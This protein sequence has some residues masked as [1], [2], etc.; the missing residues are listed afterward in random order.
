MFVVVKHKE[1]MGLVYNVL[2]VPV[3][4]CKRVK[5]RLFIKLG[6]YK[7][8]FDM[9]VCMYKPSDHSILEKF[10]VE[11]IISNYCKHIEVKVK[12][13]SVEPHAC[14]RTWDLAHI[15]GRYQLNR[16]KVSGMFTFIFT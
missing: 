4:E 14:L 5:Y 9:M 1:I 3:H 6:P 12:D 13:F 10:V 16:S 7:G 11:A 2:I 8:A 15:A